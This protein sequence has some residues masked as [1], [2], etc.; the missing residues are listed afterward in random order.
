MPGDGSFSSVA[1][2]VKLTWL[3]VFRTVA[4]SLLLVG[5]V[6]RLW[7]GAPVEEL[8]RADSLS[9]ALIGI[10]YLTTLIYGFALR[11]GKV[12]LGSAMVQALGDVVLATCVVYLTGAVESPFVFA[13]SLA[14]I[15]ASIVLGQRGAFVA[16]LTSA[17]A[18]AGVVLSVQWGLL[19]PPIGSS[20]VSVSRLLF[21]ISGNAL[22]QGLI[23]VLVGYLASQL[24]ATG[25]RLSAREADIRELVDLQNN[26]VN[27]IPSGLVTCE[28]DGTVSFVNPEGENILNLSPA[29]GTVRHLDDI[30]PGARAIPA[31]TKRAEINLETKGGV[32]SLGLTVTPL[33]GRRGSLLIVFQ[34]LTD[35][36]RMQE[37]LRRIDHLASLGRVSAQLAHEIRNP[38]AAMRGSAQL[39]GGDG[40][41]G[42]SSARLANIIVRESDR[43]AA[44]VE[45]Y[46]SLARPPPP[47][48]ALSRV[49]SIA[50]ETIEMLRADPL[51][52]GIRIEER[53]APSIAFVDAGQVRQVLINLLRNA[54][55]AAGRGGTVRVE[56]SS[57][58]DHALLRV[59]DSAGSIAADDLG[60]VFEPFYSTREGGTGL[61][62]STVHS[63][64]RMHGGSIEVMSNPKAG[65]TF[66]VEIPVRPDADAVS[67]TV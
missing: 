16:A 49:D 7:S 65:T 22:A 21:Y 67:A 28:P 17:G 61:G 57:A 13:Y 48:R 27:S 38:L 64:V 47:T 18:F 59:W 54:F 41:P 58:N 2:R 26:I 4:T 46:L 9:F 33:E 24:S 60:R 1:L 10:T 6:I 23:A 45:S 3:T 36:R 11:R 12:G 53:L 19:S 31:G 14:V 39:L 62:L 20:A 55:L 56:V 15:S 51:A 42:D 35:L 30:L 63:I 32:K 50:A 8:S 66:T 52:R 44:L 29:N 34:D 43:L 40:R 37:E 5:A 25:G